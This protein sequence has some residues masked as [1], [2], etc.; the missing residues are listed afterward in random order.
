M[1]CCEVPIL[2][3]L[4]LFPLCRCHI[5]LA[6]LVGYIRAKI[7]LL[8]QPSDDALGG[9]TARLKTECQVPAPM[10][11]VACKIQALGGCVVG[12]L[13]MHNVPACFRWQVLTHP[14]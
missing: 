2:P 6:H 8:Q 4:C 5:R 3:Y 9:H 11:T 1:R 12:R 7:A 13:S 14:G 10:T